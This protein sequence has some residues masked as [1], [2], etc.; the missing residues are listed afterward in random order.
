MR[1][2]RTRHGYA[3]YTAKH[4]YGLSADLL[5]NK[6]GIGLY[7]VQYNIESTTQEKFIS[8]IKLMKKGYIMDLIYQRLWCLNCIF[9]TEA[10][11]DKDKSISGSTY[12]HIYTDGK[13]VQI[14]TMWSKSEAVMY[15]DKL[16]W[17]I[18]IAN[19]ILMGNASEQTGYNT[20]MQNVLG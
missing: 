5:V 14:N 18:G 20:D 11:F 12:A 19:K 10:L 17:D 7:K 4:C 8:S 3:A 2:W 15:V 9:Y 1:F 16:N 13:F 6:L